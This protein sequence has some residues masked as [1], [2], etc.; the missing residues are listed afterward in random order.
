MSHYHNNPPKAVFGYAVGLT[1][2]Y[3][4]GTRALE[5]PHSVT[6]LLAAL[7]NPIASMSLSS[8][9]VV[10]IGLAGIAGAAL[11][12]SS[13][14]RA[15]N[16]QPILEI[17]LIFNVVLVAGLT[18]VMVYLWA[19]SLPVDQVGSLFAVAAIE[20][21]VGLCVGIAILTKRGPKSAFFFPTFAISLGEMALLGAVFFAGWKV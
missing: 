12:G 14:E 6:G 4:L 11:L 15:F 18:G 7:W 13:S 9:G 10:T 21:V 16:W 1:C 8:A 2:A 3:V 20:A 19:H 5:N 17:A